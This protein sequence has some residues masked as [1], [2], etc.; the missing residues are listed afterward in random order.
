MM[1]SKIKQ[2]INLAKFTSMGLGGN[3]KYLS[4]VHSEDDLIE[5]LTFA[6]ENQLRI[7]MIGEGNNLIFS[8]WGFDGIVLVNKIKGIKKIDN[9]TYQ[10][11]AG[12]DWDDFVEFAVDKNL[13]GIE[14]LSKIPG[15]VGASPV[16]NIGAYGQEVSETLINVSAIKLDD[17]EVVTLENKQC[18]FSY[19]S[20]IFK[21]EP[22]KYFITYVTFKLKDENLNPPFYDSLTRYLDEHDIKSYSPKSIR[23][24]VCAIRKNKLPDPKQVKNCGSFFINPSVNKAHGHGLKLEYPDLPSWENDDGTVKIS[25][26]WLIEKAGFKDYHHKNGMATWKHQPLV[27]VNEH[28]DHTADLIEFKNEIIHKVENKFGI[29]LSM[30]PSLIT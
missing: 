11:G 15:T 13:S 18:N 23:E 25:A 19:R 10:V 26:A 24:A 27:I 9:N 5:S 30:E 29:T 12:E 16:Q 22:N 21:S 7:L 17:L 4:E 8:D 2:D 20:S 28:A 6:K 3:A 14:C 1:N